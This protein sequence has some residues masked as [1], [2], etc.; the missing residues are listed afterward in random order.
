L[1][2]E[3]VR[4]LTA[5]DTASLAAPVPLGSKSPTVQELRAS[6]HALAQLLAKGLSATEAGLLTGYSASRIS[7]L[8]NHDPAFAE[9]VEYYRLK[10]EVVFVDA[11]ERMKAVGLD[12]LELLHERV[13]SDPGALS[14]REMGEMVELLLVKPNRG[15]S[16]IGPGGAPSSGNG[17]TVNVKFVTADPHPNLTI[18]GEIS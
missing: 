15:Q 16:P 4:D 17:V 5:E 14:I 10:R 7:I 2:I 13:L 9:L 6:H 8:K 12:T 18:D 3:F 1:L 11:L